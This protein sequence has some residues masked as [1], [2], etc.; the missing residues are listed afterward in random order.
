MRPFRKILFL[1][2]RGHEVTLVHV[3]RVLLSLVIVIDLMP[4]DEI[5]EM[6]I[7]MLPFAVDPFVGELIATLGGDVSIIGLE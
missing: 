3:A 7:L 1:P 5:A 4:I 6:A 2:S